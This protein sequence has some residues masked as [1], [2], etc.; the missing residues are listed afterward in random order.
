M[1]TVRISQFEESFVV[2]FGVDGRQIN[3]YTLA[4]TLVGIADA[5][6]AANA[7]LNP[8]YDIEVV[9]EAL[10]GGSF[11]AKL[12]SVY[13]GASNLFSKQALQAI[14]F[15]VIANFVYQHTL[16]PDTK[17]TV[18]VAAEEVVVEQG[19]TR[20][21][22]PRRVHE[23]TQAIQK[24]PEFVAGM[25]EAV[26]AIEGDTTV[27][28]LG[29]SATLDTPPDLT[30]LREEFARLPTVTE[31]PENETR[32]LP[33]QEADVQI[34]RAILEKSRRRWEFVWNGTRF[35]AP[36]VDET[37]FADFA[38]HKIRIA[39]G[40]HLKVVLRIKQRRIPGVGIFVNESY[41][42]LQVLEHVP[43][44]DTQATL[45]P[46]SVGRTRTSE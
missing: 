23:A 13:R 24:Q 11:R 3:A 14:V 34:L 17:V 38:A 44:A 41:E 4:S 10:G 5:A 15:G 30:V 21:V 16:A 18:T 40:D 39:P 2:H 26:E 36:V 29:F 32:D 1:A 8:G 43:H 25:R 9:V 20:I 33:P 7:T 19:D 46:G 22:V 35:P 6:R 37:F 27:R 12:K 31:A 28:S 45:S 42:V